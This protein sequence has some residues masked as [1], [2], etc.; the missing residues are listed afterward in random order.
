MPVDNMFG[1][2]TSIHFVFKLLI[3][4]VLLL[5]LA[6]SILLFQQTRLMIKVVEAG[7]SP[8]ILSITIIHLLIS[9]AVLFGILVFF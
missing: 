1:L 6:F 7:I 9:I 3:V 5:H 2:I 4:I 8:V